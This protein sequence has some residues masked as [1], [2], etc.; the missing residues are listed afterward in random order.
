M[1]GYH[2]YLQRRIQGGVKGKK[3][4]QRGSFT[5]SKIAMD[6]CMYKVKSLQLGWKYNEILIFSLHYFWSISYFSSSFRSKNLIYWSARSHKSEVNFHTHTNSKKI[7]NSNKSWLK[8]DIGVS[9][10]VF[11]G[12]HG[13]S[14]ILD[15]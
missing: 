1:S 15:F 5:V 13:F 14:L 8:F 12:I 7:K 2:Y 9:Q 3:T 6:Y 4:N 11:P 10:T